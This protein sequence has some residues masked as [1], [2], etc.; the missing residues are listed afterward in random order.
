[1][2][3]E[4]KMMCSIIFESLMIFLP[5]NLWKQI[6]ENNQAKAAIF[7]VN[8]SE[9]KHAEKKTINRLKVQMVILS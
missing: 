6:F 3:G 2:F 9:S 7:P 5:N 1:M 4:K 8:L